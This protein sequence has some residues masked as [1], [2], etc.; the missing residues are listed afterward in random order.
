MQYRKFLGNLEFFIEI[1]FRFLEIGNAM[2]VMYFFQRTWLQRKELRWPQLNLSNVAV[3]V[4]AAIPSDTTAVLWMFGYVSKTIQLMQH[5]DTVQCIQSFK[6]TQ[7][8]FK[9]K[10]N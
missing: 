8:D 2:I 1:T 7:M 6:S 5:Y 10:I 9:N 4:S 3:S